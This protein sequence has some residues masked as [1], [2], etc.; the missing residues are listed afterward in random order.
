M[1]SLFCL[2]SPQKFLVTQ[3]YFKRT[4]YKDKRSKIKGF[5]KVLSE[6][7]HIKNNNSVIFASSLTCL[8]QKTIQYNFISNSLI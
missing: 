7:K 2:F 5:E 3:L 8:F 4:V 1:C 6:I